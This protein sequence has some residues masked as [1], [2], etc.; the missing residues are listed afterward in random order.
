MSEINLIGKVLEI[1]PEQVIN[2]KFKKREF[3][4]ETEGEYPQVIKLECL[5][6]Y[7]GLL[8]SVEVGTKVEVTANLKGSTYTNKEGKTLYFMS[9]QVW[10]FKRPMRVPVKDITCPVPKGA[11]EEMFLELYDDLRDDSCDDLPF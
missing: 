6:K 3:V 7:C 5:N 9:L 10:K 11:M 8:D 1:F 4:I 2:N